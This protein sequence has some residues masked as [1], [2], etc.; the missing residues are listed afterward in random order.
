MVLVLHLLCGKFGLLA[1]IDGSAPQSTE[2][3]WAQADHCVHSWLLGS[4]SDEVLDFTFKAEQSA[5]ALWL[6]IYDLFTANKESKAVYLSHEFHSLTQ[7]DLPVSDYCKRMKSLADALGDVGYKVNGPQLVLNLLRGL[8]PRYSNTADDIANAK[9]LPSFA[10]AHNMLRLKELR[11]ANDV[12]NTQATAL[13]ATGTGSAPGTCAGGCKSSAALAEL[14][15]T[16][17]GSGST[18]SGNGG[19]G[20]TTSGS[21]GSGGRNNRKSRWRKGGQQ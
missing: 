13:A 7:G 10:E 8:D 21:G 3:A 19:S 11:L 18:T 14:G 12:K 16:G 1:H 20:S 15:S 9:P 4:V 5:R 2:P 17:G 6:A